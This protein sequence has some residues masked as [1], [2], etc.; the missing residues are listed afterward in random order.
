M[1]RKTG[2]IQSNKTF[3]IIVEGETEYRY[4]SEMKSIERIPSVSITPKQAKHSS[5]DSIF[6]PALAEQKSQLYDAIWCIFDYDTVLEK[7]MSEDT[8]K[9]KT[10]VEKCGIYIADSLPAFEIWFLLHYVIP[11]KYYIDQE[12]LI[13]ELQI[14]LPEYKKSMHSLY[15]KLKT[16]HKTALEHRRKLEERNK[17]DDDFFASFCNVHKLFEE[18]E[19]L[20]K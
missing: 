13:K 7:G 11:K 8:K 19:Q 12:S 20:K 17:K 1:P 10:E 5:L 2:K 6:K 16:L 3:L 9:L 15:S 14:H 4:F 18:I